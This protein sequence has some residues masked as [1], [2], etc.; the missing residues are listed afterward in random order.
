MVFGWRV[1]RDDEVIQ[2]HW[3]WGRVHAHIVRV[4]F[5]GR[6][7]IG[8]AHLRDAA[9][10]RAQRFRGTIEPNIS[11]TASRFRTGCLPSLLLAFL[12]L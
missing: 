9:R 7:L 1:E 2:I 12:A 4:G 5:N 8:Q 3:I 6:D 11:Q 10:C